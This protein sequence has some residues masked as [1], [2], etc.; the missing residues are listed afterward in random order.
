MAGLVPA[1]HAAP[2]RAIDGSDTGMADG[3]G[4]KTQSFSLLPLACERLPRRTTWM[5]GTARP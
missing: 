2:R 3:K 4:L 1:I 5:A